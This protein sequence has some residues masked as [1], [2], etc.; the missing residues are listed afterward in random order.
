MEVSGAAVSVT[1]VSAGGVVSAATVVSVPDDVDVAES[2][3]QAAA[4]SEIVTRLAT[5]HGREPTRR[6]ERVGDVCMV[7]LFPRHRLS[8]GRAIRCANYPKIECRFPKRC[9]LSGP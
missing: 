5:S 2:L 7:S 3:L 9:T 8:R 1:A 4:T 6:D